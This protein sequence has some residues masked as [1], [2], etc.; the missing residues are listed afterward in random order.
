MNAKRYIY[1]FLLVSSLLALSACDSFLDVNVDPNNP[2]E[3]SP[4]LLLSSAQGYLAYT[5]GGDMNRY[6][7]LFVQ[8]YAGVQG[9]HQEEYDIY[10]FND[11]E[12]R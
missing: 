9:Q 12:N 11:D 1:S 3:V 6:A 8:H 2:T 5:I 7:G 4:D 10:N